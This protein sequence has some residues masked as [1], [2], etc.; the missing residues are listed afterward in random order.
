M[1]INC[2]RCHSEPARVAMG[3]LA[4]ES[5]RNHFPLPEKVVCRA[6]YH[7]L[8]SQATRRLPRMW[9]RETRV[10]FLEQVLLRREDQR[11]QY[12]RKCDWCERHPATHHGLLRV[13]GGDE[14]DY[15]LCPECV[16][17]LGPAEEEML[18]TD[19][20]L[21]AELLQQKR[22]G[23]DREASFF[24]GDWDAREAVKK[25][26]DPNP[27]LRKHAAERLAGNGSREALDALVDA[28]L[29]ENVLDVREM[30]RDVVRAAG[31]A[32]LEALR[33]SALAPDPALG[34]RNAVRLAWLLDEKDPNLWEVVGRNL[35]AKGLYARTYAM[36][37][38]FDLGLSLS[39]LPPGHALPILDAAL[40]AAGDLGPDAITRRATDLRIALRG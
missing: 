11:F 40:L 30:I 19:P 29:V 31:E 25:L 17:S 34:T 20:T 21:I 3:D 22:E 6:C 33:Q 27:F 23:W 4:L 18:S 36:A 5:R 14:F 12:L 35:R 26:C 7:W 10:R 8:R 37:L 1:K 28:G 24:F 2:E 15:G 39:P 13:V 38:L 32:G 16:D 9:S